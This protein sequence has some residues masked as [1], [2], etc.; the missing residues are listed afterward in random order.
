M[1]CELKINFSK[2]GPPQEDRN[3]DGSFRFFPKSYRSWKIN[4]I[5]TPLF[6]SLPTGFVDCELMEPPLISPTLCSSY[7]LSLSSTLSALFTPSWGKRM[8]AW[9]IPDV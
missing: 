5:C 2:R 9:L 1:W 7:S 4:C 8:F 6:P 3:A